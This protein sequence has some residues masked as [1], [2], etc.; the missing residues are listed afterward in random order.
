[1][2]EKASI[3]LIGCV[4]S[5]ALSP[6]AFATNG[7]N[8]IGIGP[9]VRAMGGAGIAAPQ[10]AI[11]AVFANPAA[12]CFGEYCPSSEF[13]FAGT[14]FAPKV[15]AKITTTQG[16]IESSSDDTISP[17]PAIGLSVPMGAALPNW[18]FGLAAYGVSGLGVDYRGTELDNNS[19]YDFSSFGGPQLP[20]ASGT[21]TA[22][23]KMKFAPSVAWQVSDAWSLGLAVHIDYATL[24]LQD[25][26]SSGFAFGIQPGVIYKPTDALSFGL[27]YV[28][29]QSVDHQNVTDFDQ[30]GSRDDLEL[31]SPQQL[32]FGAA[33][34]FMQGKFLLASDIKWINWSGADG[35]EDFDWDD[36]WV[37]AIGGQYR[38]TKSLILRA[39]YN[40]GSNPV[41]EHNGW[42]GSFGPTGPNSFNTVQGKNIPTYYYE[43]FRIIGFPALVE[44]H[45][46]L[47][48]E[49]RFSEKFF[50]NVGGMYAF[51][52][53]ITE[54]GTDPFGQP[55]TL[56]STLKE[57]AL[58]LGLTWR[59]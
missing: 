40:Y 34:E 55:V 31:E 3:L 25:G 27:N 14:I 43:T 50:M 46:T 57:Y 30:D 32:G 22:L 39:G 37:F 10:D 2:R 52:N 48:V 29:P 41:N 20:L 8:L 4:M 19:F 36:Q 35:Y 5:L 47:G 23:Q 38:A 53:S 13:N 56:E 12:M 6:S 45:I 59:F 26:S 7:D 21:Y 54:Q 18:R 17:I 58:D 33:Y 44:H 11:G 49:Y 42:D 16:I 51:E 9:A 1:M 24:D 28:S 15:N